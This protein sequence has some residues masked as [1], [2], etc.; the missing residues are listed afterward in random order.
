M[1]NEV[2]IKTC[3]VIALVGVKIVVICGGKDRE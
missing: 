2:M 3:S 1:L